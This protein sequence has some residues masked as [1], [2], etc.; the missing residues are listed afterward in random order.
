MKR[1]DG[2]SYEDYKKRRAEDKAKTKKRLKGVKVWP[3]E[4]GTYM[5][6]LHGKVEDKLKS[7][8]EKMKNGKK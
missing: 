7:M 5:G 6:D 8:L 2:E 4:W 1:N 3:G